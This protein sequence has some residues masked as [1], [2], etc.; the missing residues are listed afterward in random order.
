MGSG[1]AAAAEG[2]CGSLRETIFWGALFGCTV[3]EP[4]ARM[5]AT[6]A[7]IVPAVVAA[8]GARL[9]SKAQQG[10]RTED[11]ARL[12]QP[13]VAAMTT[14]SCCDEGEGATAILRR[15]R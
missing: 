14:R 13:G 10:R 6:V 2:R 8:R 9:Q 5:V 4:A 3:W 11:I 1:G 15:R 7:A 12:L